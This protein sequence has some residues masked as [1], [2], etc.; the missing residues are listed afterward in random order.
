MSIS[1]W[2]V[3]IFGGILSWL[4]T[5]IYILRISSGTIKIDTSDPLKDKYRLEIDDLDSLSKKKRV[6]LKVDTKA[7]L[8]HQ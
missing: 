5:L 4:V 3:F 7:D 1:S 6:I 8:S 2:M